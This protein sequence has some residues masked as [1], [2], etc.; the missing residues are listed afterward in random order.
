MALTLT[1]DRLLS[2]RIN[3]REYSHYNLQGS[4]FPTFQGGAF[5]PSL[6]SSESELT[7]ETQGK[8]PSQL[9]LALTCSSVCV[10]ELERERD[11]APTNLASRVVIELCCIYGPMHSTEFLRVNTPLPSK[12]R[13]STPHMGQI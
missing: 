7:N 13:E 9:F 12:D 4:Q 2:F 1:R 10:T 8:K 6:S 5:T 3:L 11:G